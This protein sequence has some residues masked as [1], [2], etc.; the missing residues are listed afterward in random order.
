M[1]NTTRSLERIILGTTN[2]HSFVG[3]KHH[4]PH[5]EGCRPQH[6]TKHSKQ[7]D[8]FWNPVWDDMIIQYIPHLAILG[9]NSVYPPASFVGSLMDSY[10]GA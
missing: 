7:R 6:R 1:E 5:L 10:S 9:G 4:Y 8:V 2:I 3:T